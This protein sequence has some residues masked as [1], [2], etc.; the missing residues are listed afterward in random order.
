MA[1]G[2]RRITQTDRRR[3]ELLQEVGCVACLIEDELQGQLRLSLT[4]SDVH[5]LLSGGRRKGHQST[6]PLCPW[7]HRGVG[8]MGLWQTRALY[9]PSM[10]TEPRAFRDRYGTQA[11]LLARVERELQR[12]AAVDEPR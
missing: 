1:R 11:E 8:A 3:F 12:L 6:I 7:H 4:P 5:H 10:A 2:K 9:G